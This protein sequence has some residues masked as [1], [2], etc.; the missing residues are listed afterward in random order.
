MSRGLTTAGIH[1]RST[2]GPSSGP[3]V[4][5]TTAALLD[6]LEP[7]YSEPDALLPDDLA[8]EKA[9]TTYAYNLGR[10]HLV[11]ALAIAW[12]NQQETATDGRTGTTEPA[13]TAAATAAD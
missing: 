5:G 8:D 6:W 12:A 3:V 2:P 7:Q 11:R 13:A 4:P 9:R 10:Y 1:D